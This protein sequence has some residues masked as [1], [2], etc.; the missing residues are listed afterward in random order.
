MMDS[1][2]EPDLVDKKINLKINKLLKKKEK[3]LMRDTYKTSVPHRIYDFVTKYVHS[4]KYY[5]FCLAGVIIFLC[6]RFTLTKKKKKTYIPIIS[7]PYD[8]HGKKMNIA[9]KINKITDKTLTLKD[10]GH[11]VNYPCI[12]SQPTTITNESQN[13]N[14]TAYTDN[15]NN[16]IPKNNTEPYESYSGQYNQSHQP[17]QIHVTNEPYYLNNEQQNNQQYELHYDAGQQYQPQQQYQNNQQNQQT[18]QYQQ[19]QQSQQNHQNQQNQPY[20]NNQ[21]NQQYQQY[22]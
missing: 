17:N 2:N 21:N 20:Q 5:L 1:H 7:T 22:Q 13:E 12:C 6:Y 3:K 16:Y 14:N 8:L 10:C 11:S 4:N 15:I 9:A 19:N 18:Q